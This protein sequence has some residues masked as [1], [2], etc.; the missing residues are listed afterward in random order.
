MGSEGKSVDLGPLKWQIWSGITELLI[1][2]CKINKCKTTQ[3]TDTDTFTTV[4]SFVYMS[5]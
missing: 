5:L 4:G 3:S 1:K 2:L